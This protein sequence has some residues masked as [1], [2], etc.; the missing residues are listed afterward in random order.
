MKR[1]IVKE[2]VFCILTA[3]LT[4]I[5]FLLTGSFY[6]A[7][8]HNQLLNIAVWTVIGL[9]SYTLVFLFSRIWFRFEFFD[10]YAISSG[11]LAV[12]LICLAMTNEKEGV[13]FLYVDTFGFVCSI[14]AI[15]QILID[16]NNKKKSNEFNNKVYQRLLVYNTKTI[17]YINEIIDSYS[18]EKF[19]KNDI[20][21]LLHISNYKVK[22]IIEIMLK[23]GIA[24]KSKMGSYYIAKEFLK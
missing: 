12:L 10:G 5:L 7:N 11:Y 3:T 22:R 8:E 24:C 9:L 2:I 1:K 21:L 19:T 18:N 20:S 23:T 15:P 17:G 13:N 6:I 16:V 14:V 4:I